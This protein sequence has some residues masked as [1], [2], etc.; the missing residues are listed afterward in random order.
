MVLDDSLP[1]FLLLETN[2]IRL[3]NLER[4]DEGGW[5]FGVHRSWFKPPS[6][7]Y[8]VN[9]VEKKRKIWNFRSC[10]I[11]KRKEIHFQRDCLKY[12]Q[13]DTD[14]SFK[15]LVDESK[16][17]FSFESVFSHPSDHKSQNM[18]STR[19]G[20]SLVKDSHLW[21]VPELHDKSIYL[22][23]SLAKYFQRER[24]REKRQRGKNGVT[25]KKLI[26]T[27]WSRFS[28]KK[29]F[30]IWSVRWFETSWPTVPVKFS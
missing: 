30:P 4:G 23:Q 18:W 10:L 15:Y 21:S 2:V 17:C 26:N 22:V 11:L 8:F 20:G 24:E 1:L 19:E 3:P 5:G 16:R 13:M 9:L 29:K 12:I 14:L 27:P 6:H 7:S 28:F 25:S